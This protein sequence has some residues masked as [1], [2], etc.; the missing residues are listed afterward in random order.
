MGTCNDK[1]FGYWI[2]L[3][4]PLFAADAEGRERRRSLLLFFRLQRESID[5]PE[6]RESF[7][8][9]MLEGFGPGCSR[10]DLFFALRLAMREQLDCVG[11]CLGKS[12]RCR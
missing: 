1:V 7:I 3:G 4:N 5:T 9:E 2:D 8:N 11:C 6:G 10:E 12:G